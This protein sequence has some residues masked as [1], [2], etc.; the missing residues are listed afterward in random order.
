[1]GLGGHGFEPWPNLSTIPLLISETRQVRGRTGTP[2]FRIM[3]RRCPDVTNK[4]EK[5]VKPN[6]TIILSHTSGRLCKACVSVCE[7][8]VSNGRRNVTNSCFM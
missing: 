1:M 8:S 4:V 2:H 7:P 3:G 6:Q 5:D